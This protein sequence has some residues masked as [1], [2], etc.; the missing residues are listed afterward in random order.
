MIMPFGLPTNDPEYYSV[1]DS[2]EHQAIK[3]LRD[4]LQAEEDTQVE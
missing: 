4:R 3:A 1:Q 2:L